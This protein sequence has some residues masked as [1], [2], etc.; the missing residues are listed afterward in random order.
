MESQRI[1]RD[2]DGYVSSDEGLDT[3]T[4]IVALQ[5]QMDAAVESEDFALAATLRDKLRTKKV[6]LPP[7]HTPTK[8]CLSAQ[9]SHVRAC[10]VHSHHAMSPLQK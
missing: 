1:D 8:L 6:H 4:Q 7:P 5:A 3:L 9:S 2:V 10:L